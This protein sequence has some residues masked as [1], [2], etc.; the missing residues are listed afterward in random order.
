L[1]TLYV[2]LLAPSMN[3]IGNHSFLTLDLHTAVSLVA[4]KVPLNPNQSNN[5]MEGA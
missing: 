3:T 5:P 1:A 4:L 2:G